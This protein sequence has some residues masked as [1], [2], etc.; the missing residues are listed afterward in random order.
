MVECWGGILLG[1]LVRDDVNFYCLDATNKF[2]DPQSVNLFFVNPSYLGSA[3]DEY[4][5]DPESHINNVESVDDYLARLLVSVLR[6]GEALAPN[7]SIF[8]ML[9]N[10]YNIVP[11]L[12]NLVESQ[13]DLTVGQ[14]FVWDFSSTE[15]LKE[16]NYEKMGLIVHF[17]KESF[18][19]DPTKREYVVKL[20]LD[21]YSLSKYDSIGFTG[22]TIPEEL[23][24]KFILAF[25]KEG[26]TVADIFGGTGTA[27]VATLHLSRKVVYNDISPDQYRIAEARILDMDNHEN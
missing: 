10:Q 12:C 17:Y 20:P 5:G 23:Y 7:G 26:D 24:E 27:A 1:R 8:M 6:M 13:T 9:Q 16:L 19:V 14:I 22:N 4:G 15:F 2:L 21:P 3:L 18:Y 11:R 25:S